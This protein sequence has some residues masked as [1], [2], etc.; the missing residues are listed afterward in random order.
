MNSL[1]IQEALMPTNTEPSFWSK[2]G[3]W[4]FAFLNKASKEIGAAKD[5][6]LK[7]YATR[8]SWTDAKARNPTLIIGF[9]TIYAESEQQ[10]KELSQAEAIKETPVLKTATSD[11]EI[12]P[13][14]MTDPAGTLARWEVGESQLDD[15][16]RKSASRGELGPARAMHFFREAQI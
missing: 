9:R 2:L 1:H 5:A 10:A 6:R 11:T 7:K 3:L 13:P 4:G 14:Y 16:E 15:E 12:V 8:L